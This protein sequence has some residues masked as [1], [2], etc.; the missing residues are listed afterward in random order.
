MPPTGVWPTPERAGIG[1]SQVD[2]R[3]LSSLRRLL[4]EARI[5]T[6]AVQPANEVVLGVLPFLA[7]ADLQSLIV[8]ASRLAKHSRGLVVGAPF[9]V[10]IHEADHA[11]A[12]PLALPRLLAQGAVEGV[13]ESEQ[14]RLESL[15]VERFPSAV[16]TLSLG[17]FAFHRLRL[18]NGRLIAG[19][20]Q[21]YSVGPR[22]LELAAAQRES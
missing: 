12:D 6:L 8:H 15:W 2:L 7:E 3:T 13:A 17:D 1:S 10:A 22:Q 21:A 11:D 9:S 4:T 5:L 19:F 14:R 20:A 16:M 18:A